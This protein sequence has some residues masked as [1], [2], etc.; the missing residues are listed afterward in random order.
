MTDNI[1]PTAGIPRVFSV[2]RELTKVHANGGRVTQIARSV[3]L[4]QATTHRLLQSLAAE[5]IVSISLNPDSVVETW[6]RLAK[7]V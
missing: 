4:T 1:T 5:G 6:Q 2:I 3:G 7:R